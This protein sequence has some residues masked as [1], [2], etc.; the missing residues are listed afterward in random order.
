MN[1]KPSGVEAAQLVFNRTRTKTQ[2]I[3]LPSQV[4][5][6]LVLPILCFCSLRFQNRLFVSSSQK[7]PK[8]QNNLPQTRLSSLVCAL[9]I[10]IHIEYS[11]CT[12]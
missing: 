6:P 10:L 4:T 12:K 5:T 11:F 9:K 3:W 7:S 1:L 8:K 2:A